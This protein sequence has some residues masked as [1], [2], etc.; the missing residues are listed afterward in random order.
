MLQA[1]PDPTVP[2]WH[3][4]SAQ[5]HPSTK[6]SA[7][8]PT[9]AVGFLSVGTRVRESSGQALST[10]VSVTTQNGREWEGKLGLKKPG[11]EEQRWVE[12]KREERTDG[13]FQRDGGQP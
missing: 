7:S 1:R 13:D 10:S 5:S 9:G 3:V 8:I 6:L 11:S 4:R 2:S 12:P